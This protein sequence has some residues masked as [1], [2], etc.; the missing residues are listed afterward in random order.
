M[1]VEARAKWVRTSPRKAR[2]V[3][4]LVQG[5]PVHEAVTTLSL[6]PLAAAKDVTRVIQSAAANAEHNFSLNKDDLVLKS[7]KV[8][9]GPRLKRGRPRA[10]GRLFS[11]FRRTCHITAVVEDRPGA[12]APRPAARTP[13]TPAAPPPPAGDTKS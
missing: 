7:L 3:T 11:I 6:L 10:Q 2:R 9:E 1:E 4:D 5:L 12:A 8:E 13:G